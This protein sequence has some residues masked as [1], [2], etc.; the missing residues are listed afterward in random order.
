MSVDG[1]EVFIPFG[2]YKGEALE[3][4]PCTYLDWLVGEEWFEEKFPDLFEDVCEYLD[5]PAVQRELQRRL[6]R[7]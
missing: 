1:T 7:S 5:D 4:I 6:D 3:D 2:K